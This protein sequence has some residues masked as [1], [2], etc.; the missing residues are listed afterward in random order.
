MVL[1]EG[2]AGG[3]GEG[4]DAAEGIPVVEGERLAVE[5]R[6][7][8]ID[9]WPMSVAGALS[10]GFGEGG[11]DDLPVVEIADEPRRA[12]LSCRRPTGMKSVRRFDCSM[13][14][15]VG[16]SLFCKAN[17]PRVH[18]GSRCR[19]SRDTRRHRSAIEIGAKSKD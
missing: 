5:F 16:N 10:P 3:I 15:Q 18:T 2:L 9:P 1:A 13:V 4:D 17:W 11:E 6:Q 12:L 8:L 7:G 19:W 14:R